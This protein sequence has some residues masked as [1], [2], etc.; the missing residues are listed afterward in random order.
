MQVSWPILLAGLA[1][2]AAGVI[3]FLLTRNLIDNTA[4]QVATGGLAAV[5]VPL[6]IIFIIYANSPPS[7]PEE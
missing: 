4:I 3:T 2:S 5:V 6:L 1:G 7:G